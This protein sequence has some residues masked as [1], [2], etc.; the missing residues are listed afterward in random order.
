MSTSYNK[1]ADVETY[2]KKNR[3]NGTVHRLL[4]ANYIKCLR[5]KVINTIKLVTYINEVDFKYKKDNN[6]NRKK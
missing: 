3:N 6:K 2:K 4:Y 5:N 1:Q